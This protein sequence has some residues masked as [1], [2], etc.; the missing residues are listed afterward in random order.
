MERRAYICRTAKLIGQRISEIGR[1]S[2]SSRRK[3]AYTG[4][5]GLGP[6]PSQADLLPLLSGLSAQAARVEAL[7]AS[8]ASLSFSATPQRRELIRLLSTL[9]AEIGPIVDKVH[10]LTDDA[11]WVE[12]HPATAALGFLRDGLADLDRGVAP[13]FLRPPRIGSALKPQ[14]DQALAE[15]LVGWVAAIE[16]MRGISRKAACREVAKALPKMKLQVSKKPIDFKRLE[17][18]CAGRRPGVK[19]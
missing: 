9:Q 11:E 7:R 10:P 3:Q 4:L 2:M 17:G 19:R 18:W 6:E 12:S 16:N 15:W 1:Q 8:L 5:T 13:D 14:S